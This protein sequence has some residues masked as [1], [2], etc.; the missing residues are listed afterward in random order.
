MSTF[1]VRVELHDAEPSDY[2]ELHKKMESA[3][4]QR[5]ITADSGK[6]YQL[7]DA[8]Y[9][10]EPATGLSTTD[11]GQEAYRIADSVKPEPGILVTK[12]ENIEV[13]GL[14]KPT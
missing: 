14:R 3:G 6:I 8:E 11:I 13:I 7:P 9:I 1:I 12:A 2:E 4:F 10:R 5:Q